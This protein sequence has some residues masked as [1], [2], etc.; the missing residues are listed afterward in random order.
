MLKFFIG[1][2]TASLLFIS[3]IYFS[4]VPDYITYDCQN[5][6]DYD[7][8]PD[9]VIKACIRLEEKEITRWQKLI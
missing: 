1:F 5:L 6:S 7:N 4:D 3:F 2:F 8:V 9:H